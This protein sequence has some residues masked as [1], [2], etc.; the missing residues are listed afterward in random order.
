VKP[1]CEVVKTDKDVLNGSAVG[2][3]ATESIVNGKSSRDVP[4]TNCNAESQNNRSFAI[5]NLLKHTPSSSLSSSQP[6]KRVSDI[7]HSDQNVDPAGLIDE[8]SLSGI[9]DLV[10]YVTQ[11]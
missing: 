7:G 11:L 1:N 9:E 10:D 8:D 4:V 5:A 6:V 2:G 3:G